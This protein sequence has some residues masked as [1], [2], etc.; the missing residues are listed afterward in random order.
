MSSVS[1]PGYKTEAKQCRLLTDLYAAPGLLFTGLALTCL[2]FAIACL[3]PENMYHGMYVTKEY[4][5]IIKFINCRRTGLMLCFNFILAAC[6]GYKE[7][8]GNMD[9]LGIQKDLKREKKRLVVNSIAVGRG[10]YFQ[11]FYYNPYSN[12]SFYAEVRLEV[13]T[14][15]T[16]KTKTPIHEKKLPF[17]FNRLQYLLIFL[18]L[19]TLHNTNTEPKEF[20]TWVLN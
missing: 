10:D 16:N 1:H 14:P 20:R 15:N 2:A 11:T 19:W 17:P 6:E 4:T 12:R 13:L 9:Q 7:E 8:F 3:D 5:K 18:F